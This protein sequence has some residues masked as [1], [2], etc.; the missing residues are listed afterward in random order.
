MKD[1][2]V[3]IFLICLQAIFIVILFQG[4]AVGS[5]V[6][7]P[8]PMPENS[9]SQQITII[10]AGDVEWAGRDLSS[11]GSV[12]YDRGSKTLLE[13]GWQPVP[14]LITAEFSRY[15]MAKDKAVLQRMMR[16]FEEE[17]GASVTTAVA[18]FKDLKLH[19]V[20]V[21]G[22]RE[23]AIY[24]FRKIADEFNK[25]DITFVNLETPLSDEAY[26]VGAFRTSTIFSEG[27]KFAGIDVVSVANNHMLDSE[28]QGL[29]DTLNTL[30]QAGIKAVG[31]GKNLED[32]RKPAI[33]DKNGIKVAF[34][35]YTQYANSG[36]GSFATSTLAGVMPLDPLLIKEDIKRVSDQVDHVILSFHWDIYHFDI[37]KQQT[38][39]PD[40]VKFAHEMIDAGADVI[41]GHHPHVPRA[42]EYYKGKPILYSM[43]HLIFSFSLPHWMD[44][45][46]ARLTLTKNEIKQ[47][48]IL[49][50]AGRLA[51]L[52][53]PYFLEGQRARDMLT[54]LKDLSAAMGG[55]F[56]IKDDIGILT[57]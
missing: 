35:A 22:P 25:A 50:V 26:R 53:Q 12:L 27:L 31:A 39:H 17:H 24:P 23:R 13:G 46:V 16:S 21:S 45:Y 11:A 29:F 37:S 52:G 43:A 28:R 10:A 44:N 7:E 30:D 6:I 38:L 42:V 1:K 3:K 51:E 41:L 33:F 9:G 36:T 2:K 32:A 55:S 56:T 34:L 48:E 19:D 54:N 5:G 57:K 14:R 47:V 40:A 4:C 15:Y 20:E 49:P 8:E 18:S